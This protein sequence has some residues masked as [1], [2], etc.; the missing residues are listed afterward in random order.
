[1]AHRHKWREGWHWAVTT[2]HPIRDPRDRICTSPIP[3][4][5]IPITS[6]Y[7]HP[8]FHVYPNRIY[9][10][11]P[12]HIHQCLTFCISW[13]PASCVYLSAFCIHPYSISQIHPRP[14]FHTYLHLAIHIYQCLSF[15]TYPHPAFHIC[16]YPAIRVYQ[17]SAVCS[18]QCLW[19]GRS[20]KVQANNCSLNRDQRTGRRRR[21]RRRWDTVFKEKVSWIQTMQV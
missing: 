16:L 13:C 8:A 1:M 21:R 20:W 4:I 11:S 7:S 5:P 9:Q 6:F 19:E 12:V 3:G 2:C 17:C 15:Y 18:Y 10:S 14:A